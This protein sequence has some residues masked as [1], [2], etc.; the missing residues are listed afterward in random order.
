MIIFNSSIS[1]K[2]PKVYL[3]DKSML[4]LIACPETEYIKGIIAYFHPTVFGK[5]NSPS[6]LNET[7]KAIAG[8]FASQGY[9]VV[10]PDYLGYANDPDQHPYVL[11]P[12][13]TVRGTV[14]LL[15]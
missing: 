1:Y 15:N 11:Y 6:S 3:P 4:S 2:F 8:F 14:N 7:Y 12:Q 13:Q 5:W 9:A 10:M